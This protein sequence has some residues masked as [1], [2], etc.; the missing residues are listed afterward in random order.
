MSERPLILV[1]NDD[2]YHAPGIKALTEVAL[3]FGDVIKIAPD[4]PQSGMGHAITINS[5]LRM[6]KMPVDGDYEGY[7]CTGTPVDCVKIALDVILDRAPDLI[8]S[9]IN[10]G[11][12]ASINVIYSGTMSAALEGYI[13]GIPSLG[14]SLLDHSLEA[15]FEAS[16]HYVREM[17]ALVLSKDKLNFCL[18]VNI[19]RLPL[20]MIKGIRFCRQAH[21]KWVEEFD[22]RQDPSGKDYY[23]LT[24]HFQPYEE[25]AEDTDLYALQKGYVSVVPVSYDLTHHDILNKIKEWKA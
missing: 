17:I 7:Q 19:P 16:K 2:G 9:G 22:Q 21:A 11:S 13:E 25:H 20:E 15:N 12:N 6:E 10:H 14:F 8:L 18:N 5:T 24:G 23:W 1:T 4:K 3:E